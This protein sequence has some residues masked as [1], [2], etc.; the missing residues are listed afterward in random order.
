MIATFKNIAVLI[1]AD[2]ASA[3]TIGDILKKN[4]KLWTYHLQKYL[5]RL[6]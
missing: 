5:W 1:D 3:H 4:R 6:E 2:N